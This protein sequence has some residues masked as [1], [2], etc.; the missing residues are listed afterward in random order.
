MRCRWWL[1]ILSGLASFQ[2]KP[3]TTYS[4]TNVAHNWWEIVHMLLAKFGS[5]QST[6]VCAHTILDLFT[7][8]LI[9]LWA[10]SEA[11]SGG[12]KNFPFPQS[13]SGARCQEGAKQTFVSNHSINGCTLHTHQV[14][15]RFSIHVTFALLLLVV[16]GMIG[17]TSMHCILPWMQSDDWASLAIQNWCL[18]H[19]LHILQ[20]AICGLCNQS[21]DCYTKLRHIRQ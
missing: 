1:P 16:L 7:C 10:Y 6:D 14:S 12:W 19:A 17:L 18:I 2:T 15:A 11:F 4:Q 5:V 21:K 3:L 20:D 8:T 9:E 13:S